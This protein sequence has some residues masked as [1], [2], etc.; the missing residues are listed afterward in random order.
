MAENSS[1]IKH[2]SPRIL[3]VFLDGSK[4]S[5]IHTPNSDY[6]VFEQ[7]SFSAEVPY[8]IE[9]Q[10]MHLFNR[11]HLHYAESLEILLTQKLKGYVIVGGKKILLDDAPHVLIFMP[12]VLHTGRFDAMDP[13]T[14]NGLVYC[15]QFSLEELAKTVSVGT[16]MSIYGRKISDLGNSRPEYDSLMR[17]ACDLIQYD[18]DA[19]K[20]TQ[21]CLE[22]FELLAKSLPTDGEE[23]I[24]TALNEPNVQLNDL[25]NW[26]RAHIGDKVSVGDA[27]EFMHMSRYYFCHYFK[28]Q[29]GITYLQYLNQLRYRLAIQMLQAGFSTTECCL[30]CGFGSLSYF[31]QWF[32]R[33]SGRTTSDMRKDE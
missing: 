1:P 19:W 30:E 10:T 14:R 16:I 23:E 7:K 3:E 32:K 20:R 13:T 8:R 27:A 2:L 28:K 18:S 11:M 29:T 24:E 5:V 6:P 26:T 17:L 22:I 31:T 4:S 33:L 15:L 25:I 12:G 9:I 21:I